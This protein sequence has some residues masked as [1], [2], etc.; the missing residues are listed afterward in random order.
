MKPIFKRILA[1][2]FSLLLIAAAALS[3]PLIMD[4]V[5]A[6]S[7]IAQVG[8]AETLPA[9]EDTSPLAS[10]LPTATPMPKPAA[11]ASLSPKFVPQEDEDFRTPTPTPAPLPHSSTSEPVWELIPV[12]PTPAPLPPASTSEPVREPIPVFPTPAPE[13]VLSWRS[14]LTTATSDAWSARNK[15]LK[16]PKAFPGLNASANAI[17][18]YFLL[19]DEKTLL[20]ESLQPGEPALQ[21]LL[22]GI[23]S[24][25]EA[26]PA[27]IPTGE[28]LEQVINL[29]IALSLL[30][31]GGEYSSL[32]ATNAQRLPLAVLR[33]LSDEG[34]R[35]VS[36]EEYDGKQDHLVQEAQRLITLDPDGA[37]DNSAALINDLMWDDTRWKL[38]IIQ[39]TPYHLSAAWDYYLAGHHVKAV[40]METGELYTLTTDLVSQKV[41]GIASEGA[42][43]FLTAYT[44]LLAEG[45]KL[46]SMSDDG[47]L[48]IYQA[49]LLLGSQLTEDDLSDSAWHTSVQPRFGNYPGA[50]GWRVS[51]YPEDEE[52][53]LVDPA[54]DVYMTYLVELDETLQLISWNAQRNPFISISGTGLDFSQETFDQQLNQLLQTQFLTRPRIISHIKRVAR[55]YVDLTETAVIKLSALSPGIVLEAVK[56]LHWEEKTRDNGDQEVQ[57]FII[58]QV[59]DA[60]GQQY[61]VHCGVDIAGSVTITSINA[62]SGPEGARD[63]LQ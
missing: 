19:P 47:F 58:L 18:D 11:T 46:S 26:F 40:D 31:E 39:M 33:A 27:F 15:G 55:E 50:P 7:Y 57:V 3:L 51:F 56:Q 59:A 21:K 17:T 28:V 6:N 60:Q 37:M 44:H 41:V 29:P 54:S 32:L 36:R 5:M 12:F 30:S 16:A 52:T 9:E 8:F 53:R 4:S 63:N 14:L 35:S 48:K 34:K 24:N 20:A 10:P 49:A 42:E 13:T 62:L 2:L 45:E 23:L 61:Q 22:Q 38:S 1:A 25:L 43:P